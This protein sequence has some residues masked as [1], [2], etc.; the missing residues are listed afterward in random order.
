MRVLT[1]CG[2]SSGALIR[3]PKFSLLKKDAVVEL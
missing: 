2:L 3:K 1:H